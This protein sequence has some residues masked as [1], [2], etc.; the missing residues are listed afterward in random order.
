M[1]QEGDFIYM[2][3]PWIKGQGHGEEQGH[4]EKK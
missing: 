1:S 3:L 2:A 4:Q